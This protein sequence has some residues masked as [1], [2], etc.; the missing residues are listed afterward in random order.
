VSTGN[1]GRTTNDDLDGTYVRFTIDVSGDSARVCSDAGGKQP[2]QTSD[3]VY[4]AKQ[5]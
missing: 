4:C 1:D 5:L 3:N 2:G